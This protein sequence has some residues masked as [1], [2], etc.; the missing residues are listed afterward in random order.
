MDIKLIE[1]RIREIHYKISDVKTA[2]ILM[3][4]HGIKDINIIEKVSDAPFIKNKEKEASKAEKDKTVEKLLKDNEDVA[5]IKQIIDLDK[6]GKLDKIAN[7]YYNDKEEE[8]SLICNTNGQDFDID[9]SECVKKLKKLKDDIF[10]TIQT[11]DIK[12]ESVNKELL[13]KIEEY[14][15]SFNKKNEFVGKKD[16]IKWEWKE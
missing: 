4:E 12:N 7:H 6:K 13:E 10:S 2:I 1:E 3:D 9:I 14:K 8:C 16:N 5:K 11:K 15:N